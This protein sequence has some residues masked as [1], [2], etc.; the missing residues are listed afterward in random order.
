MAKRQAWWTLEFPQRKLRCGTYIIPLL[1]SVLEIHTL[2]E[3]IREI[4]YAQIGRSRHTEDELLDELL[5]RSK[6]IPPEVDRLLFR[7]AMSQCASCR[8][9][10][11]FN[12]GIDIQP[13]GGKG[14]DV[15]AGIEVVVRGPALSPL[16]E[17]IVIARLAPSSDPWALPPD[18]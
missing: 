5:E 11:E 16:T 15:A 9:A 10:P 13:V 1:R 2:A 14:G 4:A 6:L 18:G 7:F 17:D 3:S 8:L 12:G